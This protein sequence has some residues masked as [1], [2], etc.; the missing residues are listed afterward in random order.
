M[1]IAFDLQDEGILYVYNQC[2]K[3][4]KFL[5]FDDCN[6]FTNREGIR[7]ELLGA[8]RAEGNCKKCGKVKLDYEFA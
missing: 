3:C 8:V 5:K 1:P 7:W 4:G 2:P 6:L